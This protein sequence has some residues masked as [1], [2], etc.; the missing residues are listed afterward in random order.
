[1]LARREHTSLRDARDAIR[2]RNTSTLHLPRGDCRVTQLSPWLCNPWSTGDQTGV[3]NDF[4]GRRGGHSA[5]VI[6]PPLP[7]EP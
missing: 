5:I 4:I 1:M 3:S 7:F 2:Q 6:R